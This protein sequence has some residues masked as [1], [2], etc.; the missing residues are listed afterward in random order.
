MT[1]DLTLPTPETVEPS[2]DSAPAPA[3]SP[4]EPEGKS[5]GD[6]FTGAFR[7]GTILG[8]AKTQSDLNAAQDVKPR[9]RLDIFPT[10]GPMSEVDRQKQKN[11]AL[12][13]LAEDLA[14]EASPTDI[15]AK[16]F[17]GAALGGMA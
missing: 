7:S 4:P 10:V 9:D 3:A 6:S 16:N 5:F 11:A 2:S 12:E 1:D 13:R 14:Y 8:V 17:A 15:S